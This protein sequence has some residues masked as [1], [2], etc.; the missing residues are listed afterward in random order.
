MAT[1]SPVLFKFGTRAEYNALTTKAD[2][3]LYFL[4]DTGELLRGERNLAQ[5]NFY[6]GERK[7]EMQLLI[8]I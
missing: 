8:K 7:Q 2:N 6:E 1:N 4:T 3:A 5:A